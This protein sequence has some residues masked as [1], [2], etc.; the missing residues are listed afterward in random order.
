MIIHSPKIITDGLV[1]CVDPSNNKSFPVGD[2]PVKGN[3]YAWYDAADDTTFSYS[4]GTSVSQWRDKS[5]F[6]YHMIPKTNGPTRNSVLNS[7]KTITFTNTQTI[8]NNNINLYFS[9]YSVFLVHRLTGGANLRTLTADYGLNSSNWLLGAWGAYV[10]QYYAEGWVQYQNYAADTAW[11]INMGDRDASND[12]ASFYLNGTTIITNSTGSAAGPVSLGINWYSNEMSN[13]EVAEIIIYNR[14]LSA[15]EIKQVHTYLGQKWGINNTDKC[16]LDLTKNSYV[17]SLTTDAV[18]NQN[19]Q[20][21]IQFRDNSGVGSYVGFG[22]INLNLSSVTID[23][24][25]KLISNPDIDAGNT[26][27]YMFVKDNNF[28]NFLEEARVINFTVFK[29]AVSYRRVGDYNGTGIFGHGLIAGQDFGTPF[30]IDEWYNV[31]FIYNDSNGYGYYYLNGKLL[32]SGIMRQISSPYTAITAGNMDNT[33][34]SAIF[35]AADVGS[36]P[37]FFPGRLGSLKIYNRALSSSEVSSN[38]EFFKTKFINTIVE[39]G[40]ILNLDAGNPYSYAGAGST[41]Y[42]VSG[43]TNNGTLNNSPTYSSDSNGILLFNGS[44]QYVGIANSSSLQVADTFTVSAWIKASN[45]SARYGVF[46]T[47]ANNT[48][49]SWQFEVGTGSGGTGRILIS[50]VNVY[51]AQSVNNVITT[52][53]WYHITVV[54]INNATQGATFYVNGSAVSNVGTGAYTISNNSDE[55]RIAIGTASSQYFPGYIAQ[56]FVYNRALSASEI[57]QNYNATKGRFGIS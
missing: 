13:C 19:Q 16:I 57:L 22:N 15:N 40:L 12:Q 1:L 29:G 7:R 34:T 39:N 11:S 26:Y 32:N 48:T 41:I 43:S 17:G 8:G 55:K 47:R 51:I 56:I 33:T 36:Q 14:R 53:T 45:L 25:F 30:N 27:R 4:S 46:S 2:L 42:D 35:S 38:Y 52:N 3:L 49:G 9:S 37:F 44:S 24:W 20:K 28:F 54:K 10:N 6:G 18:L 50:G 21:S 23:Y 31:V 5:G